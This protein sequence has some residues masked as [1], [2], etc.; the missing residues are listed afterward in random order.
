ML[1]ISN[2]AATRMSQL[3]ATKTDD[4]VLRIVR[5]KRRMRLRWSLVRS[6]DRTFAHDGRVVLVLDGQVSESLSRRNLDLRKTTAG[7][8]LTLRS[9]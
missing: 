2:P 9:N 7:P 1:T 8:R 3:L 5:R 4:T 6:D